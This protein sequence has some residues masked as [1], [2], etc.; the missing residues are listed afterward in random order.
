MLGQLMDDLHARQI[1]RQR[2]ALATTLDRC[3]DLF[4]FGIAWCSGRLFAQLF[5]LVEHGQLR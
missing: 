3:N 5:G 2:L 1:G 4:G